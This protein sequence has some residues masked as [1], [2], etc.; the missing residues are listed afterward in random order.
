MSLVDPFEGLCS[1]A[2]LKLG[3]EPSAL[4]ISWRMLGTL[5]RT[6]WRPNSLLPWPGFQRAH[7]S[8]LLDSSHSF[9][10]VKMI[11]SEWFKLRCGAQQQLATSSSV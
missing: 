4:G 8:G 3:T 6:A 1:D 9:A 5:P 2:M 11:K 10:V 7:G